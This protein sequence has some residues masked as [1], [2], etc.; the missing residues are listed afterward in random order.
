MYSLILYCVLNSI[1]QVCVS[2]SQHLYYY[3]NDEKIKEV[4]RWCYLNNMNCKAECFVVICHFSEDLILKENA[5]LIF[6][7][8]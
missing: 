1:I 6:H 3:I 8:D 5:E 7:G 2:C 4:I